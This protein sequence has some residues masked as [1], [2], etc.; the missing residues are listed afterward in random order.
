[1]LPVGFK[2]GLRI[3]EVLVTDIIMLSCA[4]RR[5]RRRRRRR[6]GRRK[7]RRRKGSKNI[8]LFKLSDGVFVMGIT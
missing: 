8:L 7:R 2:S 4:R 1:M 5:R 6:K 3:V